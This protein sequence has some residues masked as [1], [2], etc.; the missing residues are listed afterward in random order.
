MSKEVLFEKINDKQYSYAFNN[1]Q[2]GVTLTHLVIEFNSIH[3]TSARLIEIIDK[4]DVGYYYKGNYERI[5]TTN[6]LG[7]QY[8]YSS[9]ELMDISFPIPLKEFRCMLPL[10]FTNSLDKMFIPTPHGSVTYVIAVTFKMDMKDHTV[11]L[12]YQESVDD[13]PGRIEYTINN[14]EF[15]HSIH[16]TTKNGMMNKVELPPLGKIDGLLFDTN[17]R[18]PLY[19][20]GGVVAMT[21]TNN[22]DR[23]DITTVNKN[24][25]VFVDGYITDSK[26][27][28][29][30]QIDP[31]G[32]N[33]NLCIEI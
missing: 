33:I 18:A 14:Y 12:Q 20:D 28:K 25:L 3:F 17:L 32:E 21:V 4:I 27:N 1:N 10:L 15:K 6:W 19:I 23:L 16:I 9:L 31:D 13:Y 11:M 22:V 2:A 30:T 5:I 29:L 8:T 26:G 7:M 24:K